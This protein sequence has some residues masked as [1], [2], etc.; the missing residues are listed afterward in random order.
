MVHEEESHGGSR[1]NRSVAD[2]VGV[3]TEGFLAAKEGAGMPQEQFGESV[4][5]QVY[6]S[7]SEDGAERGCIGA[8]GDGAKDALD[9]AAPTEDGAKNAVAGAPLGAGVHLIAVLLIFK[10]DSDELRVNEEGRVRVVDDSLPYVAKNQV[11]HGDALGFAEGWCE[12]VFTRPHGKKE[13]ANNEV[14]S[15]VIFVGTNTAMVRELEKPPQE[16]GSDS[17][18]SL[19]GRVHVVEGFQEGAERGPKLGSV[20][21]VNGALLETTP[22]RRSQVACGSAQS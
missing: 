18:L 13:G 4:R 2:L 20:R 15:V 12:R 5:D 3:E 1:T 19:R 14:G 16:T 10:N 17:L 8:A 21:D 22:E 9:G 11:S 6:P 7:V